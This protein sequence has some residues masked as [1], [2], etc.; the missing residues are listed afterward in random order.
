MGPCGYFKM[1]SYG[2]MATFGP[3]K[4]I[5]RS[6]IVINIAQSVTVV[7]EHFSESAPKKSGDGKL[8]ELR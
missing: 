2:A 1:N 4:E 7:M 5:Y 6:R 8:L 3:G